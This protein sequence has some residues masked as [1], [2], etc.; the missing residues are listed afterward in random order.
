MTARPKSEPIGFDMNV[1][2]VDYDRIAGRYDDEAVR[3]REVDPE[4]VKVVAEHESEGGAGLSMLDVG[5]GTGIQL[6]A[7]RRRFPRMKLAGVDLHE[8][9]L[10]AARAKADDIE[11]CRGDAAKLPFSDASF[12]YVSCQF[13]FHHIT[14]K[15]AALAE[16]ERVLR[17]G[18]RFVMTNMVP[19]RMRDWL[20]YE[21][22]PEAF[23]RDEQDFWLEI[24]IQEVLER[25][26]L[27]LVT[28]QYDEQRQQYDLSER[29][30]FYRQRYSPSHIVALDDQ[31]F[32]AGVA[33]MEA[34][35]ANAAGPVVVQSHVCFVTV[36]AHKP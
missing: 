13:C 7:N 14:E 5:C 28:F 25:V 2:R 4:L 20:V 18:G 17:P 35:V 15:A 29:L 6:L 9:M 31:H 10:R 27:T 30:E 34:A 8:G 3:Q 11:W 36:S 21:Y 33:R 23:A 22:F 1:R 32:E 24:R 26:G 16:V 12:D 19:W